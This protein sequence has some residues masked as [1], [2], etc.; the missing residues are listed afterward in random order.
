LIKTLPASLQSI[1]YNADILLQFARKILPFFE[2][3]LG[4]IVPS[5]I[6]LVLGLLLTFCFNRKTGE[7]ISKVFL[8]L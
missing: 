3:N 8:N 4:W 6:G 7:Y 5:L 1:F 2:I